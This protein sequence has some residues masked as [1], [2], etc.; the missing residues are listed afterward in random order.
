MSVVFSP[1][2][3]ALALLQ[4]FFDASEAEAWMSEQELYMISE[5]RARDETGAT[6]M[7]KKHAN[8]EKVVDDYAD[9][10]RQLGDRSRKF[11][12][13]GHPNRYR[14]HPQTEK[15]EVKGNVKMI[16]WFNLEGPIV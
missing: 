13:D 6:N 10:I 14:G 15:I 12:D 1:P 2:T 9:M 8:M 16:I 7:L 3:L 11:L 4:Y 5:D